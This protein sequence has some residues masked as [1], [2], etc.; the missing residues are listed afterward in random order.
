M[1]VE[2]HFGAH[3]DNVTLTGVWAAR[4]R[5]T[6]PHQSLFDKMFELGA[7]K[8]LT[9]RFCIP[10]IRVAIGSEILPDERDAVRTEPELEVR[11]INE[12]FTQRREVRVPVHE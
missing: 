9:K 3:C 4:D 11:A 10:P 6:G 7:S 1:H 2:V 5:S 12:G 8:E